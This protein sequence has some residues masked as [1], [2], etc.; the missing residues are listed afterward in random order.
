MKK[1]I[2]F[3][4]FSG[5]RSSALTMRLLVEHYGKN[6]CIILFANTGK[7]NEETYEFIDKCA[8]EWGYNIIWIEGVF[9]KWVK[10]GDKKMRDCIGFK[11][12]DFYTARRNNKIRKDETTPF[13]DMIDAFEMIPSRAARFCTDFMKIVP[14]EK[15]LESIGIDNYT[16]AMGIR[17]DE[18]ERQKKH[19]DKLLPLFDYKIKKED[20]LNWWKGQSFDLQLEEHQGNCDLCVLKS[21]RKL[22]TCIVENPN[23][24]D[25]Y[26]VYEDKYRIN[27]FMMPITEL[28][29]KSKLKFNRFQSIKN[30]TE[31]FGKEDLEISCF[32]GD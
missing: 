28:V 10:G 7:E 19:I 14:M 27:F 16:T 20:V 11:I 30:Q 25:W 1:H 15:Y 13:G 6:S 24:V 2:I 21:E 17:F 29:K 31:I 26:Q 32:C 3:I 4:S 12:V 5:G 22:K 8:K 9:E 23:V 18:P